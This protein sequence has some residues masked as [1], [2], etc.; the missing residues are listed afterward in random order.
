MIHVAARLFH[1]HLD[2]GHGLGRLLRGIAHMQRLARVEVLAHLAAQEDGCPP[3]HHGLAQVVV[4][5]L[6][7]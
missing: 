3:R 2:V 6:L 4:Q 7:G 1:Q 5:L